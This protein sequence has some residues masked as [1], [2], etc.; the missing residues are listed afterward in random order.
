MYRFQKISG[1]TM[2]IGFSRKSLTLIVG[3]LLVLSA[4]FALGQGISTGSIS[5]TVE[6]QQHAVVGGATVTA[7]SSGT[8]Q[9]YSSTSNSQGFFTLRGL[10]Q[11][12]YTVTVEAPK[13]TRLKMSDVVVS[14]NR[15]TAL[16]ARTLSIGT[17]EVVTVEGGAPLVETSSSQV[18][19]SFGSKPVADLPLYSGFDML[20]YF[21]P[22]VVSAGSN[23]FSN[24]NGADISVNGQRGRS[25]NFQI[26]GQANNDNSVAGPSIFLS[27]QD[28]IAEFNVITNNFGVEYGRNSGSVVNYVT[29]R[30]TNAFHGT[31]FEYH[32][33]S[34]FDSYTNQ[35]KNPILGFCLSGQDPTATG[36]TSIARI[37][38]FIE[39]RFG[40]TLG[41]PAWKDKAWFFGSYYGDR[42]RF[43][44]TAETSEGAITP[45]PAGVAAI[46]AN[47]PS[48][49]AVAILQ[50][51]GPFA[52]TAGNP[53]VL[54]VS[55]TPVIV[56]GVPIEVGTIT[57]NPSGLYDEWEVTGRAD[58][59]LSSKDTFF[60]RYLIENF[61]QT[62]ATGRFAAGAYVN[63]PGQGQQIALD[64]TRNWTSAFV[65]QARLSYSRAGFGFE[66]GSFAGCTRAAIND[67]PTNIN[68][69][70]A[71]ILDFGMQNNLPQGRLINNTQWQDNATWVIGKH[72]IK[73]GGEYARQRS[74]NV[75]LPNINGTYNFAS[76]AAFVTNTPTT[77]NLADGPTSFPFKEQDAAVYVGSDW[78][79]KDNLT[80]NFGVRWEFFEQAVNLLHDLS[81]SNQASATPFWDTTVPATVTEV[82]KIPED[83][84]NISPMFGFAW[85]P[86]IWQG[87]FGQDKTIFRGGFRINYEPA[88][89]NIFLNIATSA[90]VVNAGTVP[91]TLARLPGTGFTGA[92]V[93]SAQLG[94]IPRGV[95]PGLRNRTDVDP[96]F[97]N[98]YTENWHFGFQRQISNSIAAEVRYVGNHTVGNFQTLNAN[99]SVTGLVANGFA[100]L[101]PPGVAPCNQP[102][103]PGFASGRIDCA[104]TNVRRRAN[105]AFSIYHGVQN[106]LRIRNFHGLNAGL[107]YTFSKTIDNVSEIFSTLSGATTVAIGQNPF[108]GDSAERSLSGLDFR[109]VASLYFTYE[110]PWYKNQQGFIG[111]LLGGWQVAPTWRYNIGQNWTPS[112]ASFTN[113]SC[114]TSFNLSFVGVDSCRPFT[115]N[116]NAPV[117][118]V[119]L[120]TDG[121]A[122]DCGLV[123]FATGNPTS[124]SAVR[125]ILNDDEAAAFFGT[126]FGNTRRNPGVRGQDTNAVNMGVLK[127]TKITEKISMRFEAQALNLFNHQFRGN[128]DPFI[129]DCGFQDRNTPGCLGTFGNNFF[130]DDGGDFSNVTI[131]GIGRRRLV[132]GLKVVF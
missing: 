39:N 60:A 6:D 112:Q 24:N 30:G 124:A 46:A 18:T 132:F 13:F 109:H 64:W 17:T 102:G 123:D 80:L 49:P 15:D 122:G 100:S 22:G 26:D 63:I 114:Q 85:T 45:T 76:L 79:V 78:R 4:T 108:N 19:A 27:N 74:P 37:P 23:G 90:P 92:D 7:T 14:A 94:N 116:P 53:S 98:P 70:P 97:H 96:S 75:F 77:L 16:G 51:I 104:F 71:G 50:G 66:S 8:N 130:N 95:N 54:A 115:S 55:P 12:T 111:H 31:A 41:G 87:L 32:A 88:Y 129:E 119:G 62:A 83:K 20:A 118:T 52:V 113:S 28:V 89:Y 126:P 10:P 121:A 67:C 48:S 29:K 25:N 21:T 1:G 43:A 106:E 57:R 120:C 11:G 91:G 110:L 35:E 38:K 59:Q 61:N 117:G 127:S 33:N 101:L 93:R 82:P 72:T 103:T 107:S 2:E 65:N 105:T 9:Q 73:F 36:C 40:G 5:G 44:G 42:Q 84:N 34:K 3:L 99:P 68:F 131:S 81:A 58:I 56:N 128:P 69:T 86:R 125:Y 47:F